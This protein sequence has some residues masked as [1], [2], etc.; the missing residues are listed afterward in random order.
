MG[1]GDVVVRTADLTKRYPAATALDDLSV[2][3]PRGSTGL[4]GANGAGKTTLFR[5]ITGQD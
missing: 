3:V 1:S 5:L 2:E 4:V